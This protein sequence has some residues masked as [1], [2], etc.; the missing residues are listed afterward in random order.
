MFVVPPWCHAGSL[1][2][3]CLQCSHRR[4]S[5][6][7]WSIGPGVLYAGCGG[8]TDS[9]WSAWRCS[10]FADGI[11]MTQLE[12]DAEATAAGAAH[13]SPAAT[14]LLVA[15]A[16][17]TPWANV[18]AGKTSYQAAPLAIARPFAGQTSRSTK[19]LLPDTARCLRSHV[20]C[21]LC[22]L[23]LMRMLL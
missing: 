14:L 13:G 17:T 20:D 6:P 2:L 11:G 15:P 22:D 12:E 21:R 8:N 1:N 23:C 7:A 4:Q 9:C 5:V 19:S 3:K 18:L 16:A 10:C